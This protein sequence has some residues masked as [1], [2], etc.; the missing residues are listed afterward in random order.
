MS[1]GFKATDGRTPFTGGWQEILDGMDGVQGKRNVEDGHD[2]ERAETNNHSARGLTK[3]YEEHEK[4]QQKMGVTCGEVRCLGHAEYNVQSPL[5]ALRRCHG[6]KLY[7]GFPEKP[8]EIGRIS[9]HER[10]IEFPRTRAEPGLCLAA[11]R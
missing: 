9:S 7:I 11:A 8:T 4:T 1:N 6:K 2:G 5:G 10:G 3:G